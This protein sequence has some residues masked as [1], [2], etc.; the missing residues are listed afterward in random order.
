MSAPIV[1]IRAR[2][3]V[4]VEGE[5]EQSF[6]AWLQALSQKELHVHLDGVLL[7]GGGFKSMLQKTVRLHKRRCRIAGAY[8]DRFLIVD[9]DRAEQGDWSIERLRREAAKNKIT[10]CVQT[11]N[12]EGLLLRMMPGMKREIPDAASAETRLKSR[13]PSYQKPVNAHALGRQF[14]LDDLLR[15][16]NVDADLEILLRK[17]G[18]MGGS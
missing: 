14:S 17:I 1:K 10:V 13:W 7:G 6:L 2:F 4:A 3:F 9:R 15:V 11:P 5:S 12:H 16:A 8:R 18:L